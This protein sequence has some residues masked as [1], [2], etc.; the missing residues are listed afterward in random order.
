MQKTKEHN[1]VMNAGVANPFGCPFEGAVPVEKVIKLAKAYEDMGINIM[2]IADS[3]GTAHPEQVKALF[4]ALLDEFP[5]VK[6]SAHFHDM[7]GIRLANVYAAYGV[8]VSY[9]ETSTSDLG[10][11]PYV[12]HPAR[13]VAT[14]ELVSIFHR[15]DLD[16]GIDLERLL[17]TSR[18]ARSVVG[19][20][21]KNQGGHRVEA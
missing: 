15:I 4:N 16:T 20:H 8:G 9:F 13:N 1:I 17:D 3:I 2:T 21:L 11:S 18:Y 6:F 5:D 12:V 14:E 7:L 19:E 10:G